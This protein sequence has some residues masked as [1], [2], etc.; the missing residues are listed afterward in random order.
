MSEEPMDDFDVMSPD[1]PMPAAARDDTIKDEVEGAFKFA[2]VGAGQAGG[3][4]ASTFWK[5]GYRRALAIN[6]AEQDLA[7]A[8]LPADNKYAFG[9]GGAGKDPTV[10]QRFFE[11][12]REDVLDRMRRAFGPTFDRIFVCASAAGGTGSGTVVPLVDT[13]SDLMEQLKLEN[14]GVGV[15][16]ALPKNSEG[17]KANANA[18]KVLVQLLKYVEE[19]KVSPL[20]VLDNERI[21]QIHP[22][23]AVDPFWSTANMSICSLFNLFNTIAVRASTY[24]TFDHKDFQTVLDA[25]LIVFGATPLEKWSDPTD[26]SYAIRENL[27]QNILSGGIDLSTGSV[28]AGIVIGGAKI[29]TELPHAN[30][31]HGF[32]QLNRMLGSSSTVHR[33][34]YRG[35]KDGLAIYTAIG[36]LGRPEERLMDLRRLGDIEDYDDPDKPGRKRKR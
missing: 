28:G 14:S 30:L 6:T 9:S 15:I 20:I 33:G 27:R 34:I 25:G 16:I 8:E 22:G 13:A 36:G 1:I 5:L 11:E 10:A 18:Y 24:E 2:F 4:M 7:T 31:D 29:M 32:A 12:K 3:R 19:K 17:K 35:S 23:L 21:D 26:I